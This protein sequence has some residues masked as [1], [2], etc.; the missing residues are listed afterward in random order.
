M[1]QSWVTSSQ[2]FNGSKTHK[3]SIYHLNHFKTILIEKVIHAPA[4]F[5]AVLYVYK[6]NQSWLPL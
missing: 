6:E 3:Y 2:G 1:T 5:K 4:K